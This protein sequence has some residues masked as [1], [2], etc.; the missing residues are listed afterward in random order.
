MYIL[1]CLLSLLC[2]AERSVISACVLVG[3]GVIISQPPSPPLMWNMVNPL[4]R[5]VTFL[6]EPAAAPAASVRHLHKSD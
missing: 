2:P 4:P 1:L 5:Y 6:Q 3:G